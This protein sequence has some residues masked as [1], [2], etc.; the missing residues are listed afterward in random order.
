MSLTPPL[1]ENQQTG[2]K[3]MKKTNNKL[4]YYYWLYTSLN[5]NPLPIK[6]NSKKPKFLNWVD[7]EFSIYDFAP[8][9]NIGLR[10]GDGWLLIDIDIDDFEITAKIANTIEEELQLRKEDVAVQ[11]T[12][13]GKYH[14]LLRVNE[15]AVRELQ[16]RNQ[17]RVPTPY[18]E[19]IVNEVGHKTFNNTIDIFV[20]GNRQ[21]LAEPSVINGNQYKWIRRPHAEQKQL[22]KEDLAKLKL[23]IESWKE[24]ARKKLEDVSSY[25]IEKEERDKMVDNE[26]QEIINEIKRLDVFEVVERLGFR[27]SNRYNYG[28]YRMY[29]CIFHPPDNT[30][31]FGVKKEGIIKDFHDDEGYDV[32]KLV[33][34][35]KGVDFRGALEWFEKEFGIDLSPLRYKK[36][37]LIGE[38][39]DIE[40]EEL[41]VPRRNKVEFF[42]RY[43][44]S[45][46]GEQIKLLYDGV[47]T[48]ILQ[49]GLWVNLNSD[50]ANM[51]IV[52]LYKKVTRSVPAEE[53]LKRI[54]MAMTI[55]AYEQGV[56]PTPPKRICWDGED[57]LYNAGDHVIRITKQGYRIEKH[58]G[59]FQY[60]EFGEKQ[61]EPKP[62]DIDKL[63]KEFFDLCPPITDLE[64]ILWFVRLVTLFIPNIQKPIMIYRGDPS[65]GKTTLAKLTKTL[66][67]PTR[68]AVL[69]R[70]DTRNL[71]LFFNYNEFGLIDNITYITEETGNLLCAVVTGTAIT[72]RKLYTNMEMVV[73]ELLGTFDITTIGLRGEKEDLLDRALII[74]FRK[75]NR[76]KLKDSVL[77]EK[78]LAKLKPYLLHCIYTILSK[79][80]N[81]PEPDMVTLHRFSSWYRW[82]YRIA[83]VIGKHKEFEI[84][85]K[86][87]TDKDLYTLLDSHGSM[88]YC[89]WSWLNDRFIA[90]NEIKELA[91][92]PTELLKELE[93]EFKDQVEK[94][95]TTRK[96]GH[97]LKGIKPILMEYNIELQHKH[98]VK[99][100]VWIFK[101]QTEKIASTDD[102]DVDY[103]TDEEL[104][105]YFNG[106]LTREDLVRISK[107]RKQKQYKV[108]TEGIIEDPEDNSLAFGYTREEYEAEKRQEEV[109]DKEE[110]I[111]DSDLPED[112][113]EFNVEKLEKELEEEGLQEEDEIEM[114]EK[115]KIPDLEE[116]A[117]MKELELIDKYAKELYEIIESNKETEIVK[118]FLQQKEL[119]TIKLSNMINKLR[120][121]DEEIDKK[122]I[123]FFM[124]T[125]SYLV[126]DVMKVLLLKI[127]TKILEGELEEGQ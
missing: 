97:I 107:E 58:N 16:L 23:I 4:E 98:N 83:K 111:E 30:P 42:I 37:R 44:D 112:A 87:Q 64:K 38:A 50:K 121:I 119:D 105:K 3:K 74:D 116:E 102:Y 126:Y 85:L 70:I 1:K 12:A 75:I 76:A 34:K 28:D 11:R 43:L 63:L 95:W 69:S 27:P 62:G 73:W 124:E 39:E 61:P 14:L 47:N 2:G 45:V 19:V 21:F 103:I 55:H 65:S 100:A 52:R 86:M 60:I 33:R 26:L 8:E 67:D 51:F 53:S 96:I 57:L 110:Q 40:D 13:S 35:V 80:M 120:S 5:L 9:D 15:I 125:P 48:Y 18:S 114:I 101:K 106:E 118:E 127:R 46:V 10:P 99:G 94:N 25:K 24:E 17:L 93:E 31:S 29:H 109:E 66:F 84:V 108:G 122:I 6:V 77:L 79:A 92:S 7:R 90:N 81:I 89:L 49:D 32:I 71:S 117:K 54:K 104:D 91:I 123:R 20:E 72:E 68:Q 115:D 59:Y 78:R 113:T 88:G 22:G 82:G 36:Q 41:D 56:K